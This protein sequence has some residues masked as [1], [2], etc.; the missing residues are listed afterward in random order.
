MNLTLDGF[1]EG[2]KGDM[3]W[4]SP[5][6]DEGW[7]DLFDMTQNVD[8][9]LLGRV[10]YT[11]YR[12]HW[13]KT[14]TLPKPD[15]NELKYARLAD[16]TPHIVFSDTL[17]DPQ[18]A[19]TTVLPGSAAEHVRKLKQQAGK[20]IQIVGGAKLAATLIDSGLVDEY[21]FLFNPAIIVKGKSYFQQLNNK[22][23]LALQDV[24]QFQ[25]GVVRLTYTPV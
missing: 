8:L 15:A 13:V 18:W 19:N 7:N 25:S 21:R 3:S 5:D 11:D 1:I 10:M 9:F 22:H 16:R 4:M 17:K 14:L 6:D 20:N 2:E 23:K 12:N 24:K